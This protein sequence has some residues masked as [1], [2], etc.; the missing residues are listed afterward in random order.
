MSVSPGDRYLEYC[1]QRS[2]GHHC[3]IY[4]PGD[5][6][7]DFDVLLEELRHEGSLLLPPTNALSSSV[8][9]DH[10]TSG[11]QQADWMHFDYEYSACPQD[12][13]RIYREPVSCNRVIKPTTTYVWNHMASDDAQ[14]FNAAECHR[15]FAINQRHLDEYNV[16][17][18]DH[19]LLNDPDA[20]PHKRIRELFIEQVVLLSRNPSDIVGASVLFLFVSINSK[21]TLLAL[22]TVPKIWNNAR[23]G[24]SETFR[25]LQ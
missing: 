25:R 13:H 6:E 7:V 19:D 23:F 4:P 16:L 14:F 12:P 22:Q 5:D 11:F 9:L 3:R 24:Q 15:L 17:F 1:L 20:R 21:L 18:H 2:L 8:S 10:F